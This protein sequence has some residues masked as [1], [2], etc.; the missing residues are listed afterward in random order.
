[1]NKEHLNPEKYLDITYGVNPKREEEWKYSNYICVIG[2]LITQLERSNRHN[3]A[4]LRSKDNIQFEL[5]KIIQNI[6]E[7]E[8]TEARNIINL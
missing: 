3:K 7:E 2:D 8:Y 5:L 1:M 6:S 4:L